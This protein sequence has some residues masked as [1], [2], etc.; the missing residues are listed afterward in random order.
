MWSNDAYVQMAAARVRQMTSNLPMAE[1]MRRGQE[2][3]EE[4]FKEIEECVLSFKA[5][6]DI[7][8]GGRFDTLSLGCWG[9]LAAE[10]GVPAVPQHIVAV[11][12]MGD[13]IKDG[14]NPAKMGPIPVEL[15]QEAE[16]YAGVLR[17]DH[18]GPEVLKDSYSTRFTDRLQPGSLPVGAEMIDG[19]PH[20]VFDE[21]IASSLLTYVGHAKSASIP[22]FWRPWVHSMQIEVP[23]PSY[24]GRQTDSWPLEWRVFVQ[25]G[26]VAGISAYYF[27]AP[28]PNTPEIR[29]IA[30]VVRH[31]T[32]KLLDL[33]R[34]RGIQPWHPRYIG[35]LDNDRLDFT[36]D[37][38]T[39]PN[40]RPVLLEGGP[41]CFSPSIPMWGAHPCC[42]IGREDFRGLALAKDRPVVPLPEARPFAAASPAEE[43][44]AEEG[45]PSP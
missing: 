32:E 25:A 5:G 36:I 18:I 28:A 24:M 8:E 6:Y 38:L 7:L 45:G 34:A 42:F 41:T 35:Q 21:R 29:E 37:F 20:L 16:R 4:A 40:G 19:T 13:I 9:I 33:L 44:Q 17:L 22:V 43:E 27:Q 10:A 15:P 26:E 2:I 3:L 30:G 31:E 23:R 39:L 14:L 12:R 1:K 11:L